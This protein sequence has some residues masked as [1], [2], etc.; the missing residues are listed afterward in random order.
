MTTR[1]SLTLANLVLAAVSI[2]L[3]LGRV[4]PNG[5]YGFRTRLTLSSPDIWYRANAFSGWALLIAAGL[6]I[7]TLWLVPDRVIARPWVPIAAFVIP[8]ILS[9][10]A[11]MIYLRR[12]G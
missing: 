3:I 2:P 1:I 7:G 8:A 10:V 9:L 5:S 6:S 11:S 4:P 12:F